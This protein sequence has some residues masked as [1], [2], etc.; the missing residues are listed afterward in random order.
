[1]STPTEED[2]KQIHAMAWRDPSFRE[3]LET[4][5]RKALD[6]YGEKAGKS[7]S[8]VVEVT[9]RPHGVSDEDL[10]KQEHAKYP[11]ACC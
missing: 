3:L 4:D 1:M 8:K 11:P 2:W 7:F 6:A 5:P 10:H 9:P